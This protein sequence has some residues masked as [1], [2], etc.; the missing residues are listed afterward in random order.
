MAN[1][2]GAAGTPAALPGPILYIAGVLPKLSETFVYREV[3]A[4]RERGIRV[5]LASVNPPEG[6]LGNPRLEQLAAETIPVYGTGP[7]RLLV[8][9][10]LESLAHPARTV[11]TKLLALRHAVLSRDVRLARRPRV[12]WQMLAALALAR[13]VRPLGIRHIHAHM[14]HVPATIAMYAAGQLGIGFS[15]TGHANDIFPNRTLL[16][17]KLRRARFA[18]CIS[19]WHREF[20]RCVSGVPDSRLPVVRCGVEAP[21]VGRPGGGDRPRIVGVGRL[22]PKKGFDTLIRAAGELAGGGAAFECRVIGDGPQREDLAALVRDPGLAASVE[23]VGALPN[24]RVLDELAAADL[25]VLPCRV[26]PGGDRDGIPVV[27]MEAM[28]RGVC[29]ISGDL[30]A[31]RELVRHGETGLMVPPG[32]V[33]PLVTAMRAVLADRELRERLGRQG[34]AWVTDEFSAGVNAD[35]LIA[36]F[37]WAISA[38]SHPACAV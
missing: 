4:L 9:A 5:R 18:S 36:A 19:R 31:I 24:D 17:E 25:F 12:I 21:V 7:W 20:Y 11:G 3:F 22:V 1:A 2:P 38:E 34:R 28:V 14:A 8:D 6:G 27:L 30:P 15:F 33:A 16:A 37:T 32:E 26:D 29:V 23:L 10:A 35:R 13:R